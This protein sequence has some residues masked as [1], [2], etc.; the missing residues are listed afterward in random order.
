MYTNNKH[1]NTVLIQRTS[2]TGKQTDDH[3]CAVSKQKY[4]AWSYLTT[5]NTELKLFTFR[6]C[7]PL[8]GPLRNITRWSAHK[9]CAQLCP[10]DSP[11]LKC[12]VGRNGATACHQNG[13]TLVPLVWV[14][15]RYVQWH[16]Y[17]KSRKGMPPQNVG[18]PL[19]W[20]HFSYTKITSAAD[21]K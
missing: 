19:G 17:E 5:V 14:K 9:F 3:V 2:A 11:V 13:E 16:S 7:T 1:R 8:L 18:R 10:T 6:H 12:V 20:P 21:A 4:K 15:K